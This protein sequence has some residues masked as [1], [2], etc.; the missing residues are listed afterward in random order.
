MTNED[1]KNYYFLKILLLNQEFIKTKFSLKEITNI[2]NTHYPDLNLLPYINRVYSNCKNIEPPQITLPDNHII[3]GC[4]F[5][6]SKIIFNRNIKYIKMYIQK[7]E[8]NYLAPETRYF[9]IDSYYDD[10]LAEYQECIKTSIINNE[11]P[12]YSTDILKFM[13]YKNNINIFHKKNV[14]LVYNHKNRNYSSHNSIYYSTTPTKKLI[15]FLD[16]VIWFDKSVISTEIINSD[17]KEYNYTFDIKISFDTSGCN[18]LNSYFPTFNKLLKL[19]PTTIYYYMVFYLFHT[20]SQ[21]LFLYIISSPV[22]HFL[23][24]LIFHK[25]SLSIL[26]DQINYQESD[27]LNYNFIS[28]N[29]SGLNDCKPDIELIKTLLYIGKLPLLNILNCYKPYLSTLP[30][31]LKSKIKKFIL[32]QENITE[33]TQT[34][35]LHKTYTDVLKYYKATPENIALFELYNKLALEKNTIYIYEIEEIFEQLC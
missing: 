24:P 14:Y 2:I 25:E 18:V 15:V 17:P 11:P 7:F 6:D 29:M 12:V 4:C 26:E 20:V 21:N 27:K 30:E 22:G 19:V 9:K 33:D 5:E 28:F 32:S 31:K 23:L 34:N 3:T 13:S 16:P 1:E 35:I 8:E 10:M